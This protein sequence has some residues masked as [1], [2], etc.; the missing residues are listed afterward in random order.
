[1]KGT[2]DYTHATAWHFSILTQLLRGT[3]MGHVSIFGL[4]VACS[5]RDAIHILLHIAKPFVEGRGTIMTCVM[6]VCHSICLK[7]CDA[8]LPGHEGKSSDCYLFAFAQYAIALS[9]LYQ[10]FWIET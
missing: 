9:L 4:T 2:V 10:A 6:I 5:P 7:R 3:F 1:M 8:M